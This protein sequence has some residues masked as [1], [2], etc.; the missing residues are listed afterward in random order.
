MF[1]T[2]EGVNLYLLIWEL[3]GT[4][5]NVLNNVVSDTTDITSLQ[6]QMIT[7]ELRR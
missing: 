7:A 3:L 4:L 2:I 6:S 1:Y 5:Q